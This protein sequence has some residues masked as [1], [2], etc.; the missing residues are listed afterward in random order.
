[1]TVLK[2][3]PATLLSQTT[4]KYLTLYHGSKYIITVKHRLK[5]HLKLGAILEAGIKSELLSLSEVAR[6]VASALHQ[7][8]SH[9][10]LLLRILDN[11]F[12]VMLTRSKRNS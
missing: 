10:L 4:H 9:S 8:L 12:F 7:L 3:H 11:R 2:Q 1:M 5:V 6:T